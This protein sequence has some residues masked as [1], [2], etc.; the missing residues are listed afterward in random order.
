MKPAIVREPTR[1]LRKPDVLARVPFSD[2]TLWRA[3]RAGRFPAAIKISANAVAWRE[4]DVEQWIAQ[5]A[6][7]AGRS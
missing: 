4:Q 2:T 1:L 5:R 6:A 7:E 3:V